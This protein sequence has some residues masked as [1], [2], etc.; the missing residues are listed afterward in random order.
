MKYKKM[1]LKDGYVIA[2]ND[3]ITIGETKTEDSNYAG[4]LFEK[5][6]TLSRYLVYSDK[7]IT[8][9]SVKE[10]DD[11]YEFLSKYYSEIKE[12]RKKEVSFDDVIQNGEV[13]DADKWEK[14][15]R[16]GL[17]AIPEVSAMTELVYGTGIFREN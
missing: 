3:C 16:L 9:Y 15:P 6:G 5:N 11:L 13:I 8:E 1:K 7:P 14:A 12:V 4:I 2:P 10:E 17:I